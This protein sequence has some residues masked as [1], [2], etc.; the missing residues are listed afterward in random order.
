MHCN[1]TCF[2]FC[3]KIIILRKFLNYL[4]IY[5]SDCLECFRSNTLPCWSP[6]SRLSTT[7]LARGDVC[8]ALDGRGDTSP[9]LCPTWDT[10]C[11]DIW[12]DIVSFGVVETTTLHDG[13]QRGEIVVFF[14]PSTLEHLGGCSLS[15]DRALRSKGDPGSADLGR[16]KDDFL[17]VTEFGV[18]LAP[19]LKNLKNEIWSREQYLGMKSYADLCSSA[20][21]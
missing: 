13:L 1:L 2:I 16:L 4:Y 3:M 12:V 17:A 18:K 8:R 7:E 5:L 14:L 6:D 19:G 11:G 15:G 10:P 9:D 21:D 20:N